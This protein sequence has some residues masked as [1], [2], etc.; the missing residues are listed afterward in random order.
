MQKRTKTF[1]AGILL[2]VAIVAGYAFYVAGK[3][4]TNVE[5]FK[6][7]MRTSAEDLYKSYLSNE[8]EADKKYLN[9]VLEVTG[10]VSSF[11]NEDGKHFLLLKTDDYGGINCELINAGQ[12]QLSSITKNKTVVIKGR[13]SGFLMDVNLTDC[14][15]IKQ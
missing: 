6:T 11:T 9:K 15:I 10:L 7:D 8:A 2:C 14:V 12:S 3:P 1:L 13:C 5:H 4:H